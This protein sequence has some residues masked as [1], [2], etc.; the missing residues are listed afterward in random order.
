MALANK[1]PNQLLPAVQ[2]EILVLLQQDLARVPRI[3][4]VPIPSESFII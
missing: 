1:A 3:L 2:L 4:L